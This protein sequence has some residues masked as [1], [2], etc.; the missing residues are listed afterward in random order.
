MTKRLSR[1]VLWIGISTLLFSIGCI[2]QNTTPTWIYTY[3]G[4]QVTAEPCFSDVASCHKTSSIHELKASLPPN[5]TSNPY[6]LV[7]QWYVDPANLTTCASDGN[8]CTSLSCG[9]AGSGVGPCL[10]YSQILGRLGASESCSW[11][12]P[13]D[14]TFT[15]LSGQST[16]VNMEGICNYAVSSTVPNSANGSS[17]KYTTALPTATSSGTLSGVVSKNRSTSA[18]L[19]ATIGTPTLGALVINST[20]GSNAIVRIAGSPATLTQPLKYTN[21]QSS[22]ATFAE[23]DTWAN[24]DSY[25]QYILYNVNLTDIRPKPYVCTNNERCGVVVQQMTVLPY[26]GSVNGDDV[27][28]TNDFTW[29]QDV[30]MEKNTKLTPFGNTGD[31]IIKGSFNVA[32][33]GGFTS[34][35]NWGSYR[36]G[37]KP[38]GYYIFSGFIANL[39]SQSVLFNGVFLDGDITIAVANARF[40]GYNY[41]GAVDMRNGSN[42]IIGSGTLDIKS[43]NEFGINIMWGTGS[44]DAGGG[45][46]LYKSGVGNAANTFVTSGNLDINGQTLACL[47]VPSAVAT[48]FT[49]NKTINA[50]N[51]DTDLGGTSGCYLAGAGSICNYGP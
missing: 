49:C 13:Q 47:E 1:I 10:T 46:L 8:N 45:T 21:Q 40:M 17:I 6:T 3:S 30:F 12:Y 2:H 51:L 16:V 7:T 28:V 37:V 15:W 18:E 41:L 48:T 50:T 44:L 5:L 38:L 32:Y 25:A 35:N 19:Q 9:S 24:G 14:T 31:N 23:D 43:F 42:A 20:R 4:N 33:L 11:I 29:L 26:V 27:F 22:N 36:N 34:G 39:A